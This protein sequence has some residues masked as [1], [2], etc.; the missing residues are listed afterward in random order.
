MRYFFFIC[1]ITLTAVPAWGV[2]LYWVSTT[3]TKDLVDCQVDAD[4]GDGANA[5]TFANALDVPAGTTTYYH[6]GTYTAAL[7]PT[8]SGYGSWA[9]GITFMAV[10]GE[11]VIIDWEGGDQLDLT[12]GEDYI[13]VK[14][15]TFRDPGAGDAWFNATGD[16]IWIEGCTFDGL[17]GTT[18]DGD[19]SELNGTSYV[20]LIN[21]TWD[22]SNQTANHSREL[23]SLK[24]V[25]YALLKGNT[26]ID[27]THTL[28]ITYT[29]ASHYIAVINNTFTNRW[30]QGLAPGASSTFWLISGNTF[31][32]HGW[33]CANNPNSGLPA[34]GDG[35]DDCDQNGSFIPG[36]YL[37]LKHAGIV[38]E[39]VFYDNDVHINLDSTAGAIS[40]DVWIYHNT[41]YNAIYPT[42]KGGATNGWMNG[43]SFLSSMGAGEQYRN[44]F[45]GNN[46]FWESA[47]ALQFSMRS[48]GGSDPSGNTIYNNLIGDSGNSQYGVFDTGSQTPR[49][50]VYFNANEAQW[51]ANLTEEDGN[52]TNLDP[53]FTNVGT[54]SGATD[55]TPKSGST[56]INRG[57]WLAKAIEASVGGA[58]V[59]LVVDNPT[60]FF[61]GPG[62]PWLI[63]H[64]D[65]EADTIYFEKTGGGYNTIKIDSIDYPTRTITLTSAANW[66][67]EA[68][69]YHRAFSGSG[70]DLGAYEYTETAAASTTPGKI[71]AGGSGRILFD[72]DGVGTIQ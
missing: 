51:S 26:F 34:D 57:T 61:S 53:Q 25:N 16:Y 43:T 67:N 5:C 62:A 48:D 1:S 31:Y 24:G 15:I 8:N 60:P 42:K 40:E 45:I 2:S 18:T 3:G 71:Q 47:N 50:I 19:T 44:G 55:W 10:P 7:N 28:I 4:P 54:G 65:V 41:G 11:T 30:E 29:L 27:G 64:A 69:V 12:G 58:D 14:N 39:N 6:A 72:S 33:D 37:Q 59:T 21:N 46:I 32:N 17:D 22:G 70:P 38:R 36:L 9:S 68:K 35:H 49:S 56:A 23:L 66:D 13:T 52:E 63:A 20:W